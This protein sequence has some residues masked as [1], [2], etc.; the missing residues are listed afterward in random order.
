MAT[1]KFNKAEFEARKAE[2]ANL[3]AD[4]NKKATVSALSDRVISIEKVLGIR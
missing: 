1:H 2:K 3:K 4:T